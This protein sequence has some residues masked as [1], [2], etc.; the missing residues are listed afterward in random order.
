MGVGCVRRTG[1]ESGSCVRLQVGRLF[2][3]R[4]RRT[5]GTEVALYME[6][7]IPWRGLF[8]V[9]GRSVKVRS[10][11]DRNS[12]Q[13]RGTTMWNF[14]VTV[15]LVVPKVSKVGRRGPLSL[16]SASRQVNTTNHC[17]LFARLIRSSWKEVRRRNEE[18][19]LCKENLD[20]C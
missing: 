5:W 8:L 18:N 3:V 11:C 10:C 15:L 20:W 2:E 6:A 13:R 17:N 1:S 16:P 19:L 4:R 12:R 9:T 7:P 14:F